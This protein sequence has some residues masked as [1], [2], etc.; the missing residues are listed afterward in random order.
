[1]SDQTPALA[2]K[3]A[4][5]RFVFRRSVLVIFSI[6]TC[7]LVNERCACAQNRKYVF[8]CA[9]VCLWVDVVLNYESRFLFLAPCARRER[10]PYSIKVCEILI[11]V[12]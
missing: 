6:F 2:I 9:L 12:N 5:G 11:F 8:L 4:A 10:S 1:V 7:A 3:L